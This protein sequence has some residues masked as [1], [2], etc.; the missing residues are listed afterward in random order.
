MARINLKEFYHWY[1][2]DEFV[3]VDD[4]VAGEL[5]A[6]KRHEEN[7][8][9]KMYRYKA[10]YSLDAGDGTAEKASLLYTDSP[11]KIIE[12]MEHRCLLCCAL[13]SLPE[14]Q[15]RRIEANYILGKSKK[16]IADEEGVSNSAVSESINRGLRTMKKTLQNNF[17]KLPCPKPINCP[18]ICENHFLEFNKTG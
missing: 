2:Q 10:Y 11:E 17:K 4:E 18:D 1:K 8:K 16:E 12:L 9:R 3:E 14:I 13:N 6:S 5:L 15:G 7:Y